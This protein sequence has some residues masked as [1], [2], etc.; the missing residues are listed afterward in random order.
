[1]MYRHHCPS[2]CF[3][4]K[5]LWVFSAVGVEYYDGSEWI[6]VDVGWGVTFLPFQYLFPLNEEEVLILGGMQ[7]SEKS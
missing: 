1:M 7:G 3:L 4:S 2:A 5:Q 6:G